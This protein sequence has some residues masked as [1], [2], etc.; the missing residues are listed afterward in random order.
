MKGQTAIIPKLYLTAR[1]T[2]SGNNGWTFTNAP[3]DNA[4]TDYWKMINTNAV[5]ES[6]EMNLDAYSG[7][8]CVLKLGTFGGVSAAKNTITVTISTNNGSTWSPLTTQTPTASGSTAM[9]AI[10]LSAYNGTQ[11]K[12]R[13]ANLAGDASIGVRF[14]EAY[15][16]GTALSTPPTISSLS[17]SSGCIGSNLTINGT[18]LSGATSV[19]IGGTAV[20]SITSNSSTQI[21]A[22]VGS[23][24]TG[25]VSV[26]TPNGTATSTDTYTVVIPSATASNGGPYCEGAT[27]QLTGSPSGLNSYSW[28]GPNG[29]ASSYIT[30]TIT[31]D[32][33]FLTINATWINNSTIANWYSQRTGTGTTY[34]LDSGSSTGGGLYS[35]GSISDSDRAIGTIGS[36]NSAA[37]S[38][39]H[40]LLLQNT[41]GYAITD[42][43]VS[44]TLEQWRNSAASAQSITFY[45]KTSSSPITTL[46]PGSTTGWTQV[47]DLTLISPITGGTAGALDGNLSANKVTASNISIPSLSL[48]NNDY[49]MLKWE[50][51]D[52]TGND[53]GIAID[54]VSIVLN[55]GNIGNISPSITN[56]T[57]IMSGIY[58]LKTT[59]S[60]GCSATATTNV[61]VNP[62]PLTSNIYHN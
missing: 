2:P 22:V 3:I 41:T 38:F 4:A 60:L 48:A 16:S 31:Q 32:F 51:P 20:S 42:I 5:I 11:V 25:T 61:V 50:D 14:F 40:G 12:L 13:F 29:Y 9:T 56:A 23:G 17:P 62:N 26:T 59:N 58:T 33:N 49:I 53:H 6:P 43:K 44:Y 10:N 24:T 36:G 45:Y 19:T 39:A 37:G 28:V 57:T 27:I 55:A 35:Y 15:I 34:A 30:Q 46:N 7:E 8:T 18:N 21:V 1:N 54:D 52:H 47:T